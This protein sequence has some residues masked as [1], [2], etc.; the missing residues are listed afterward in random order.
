MGTKQRVIT[1]LAILATG[2]LIML[3]LKYTKSEPKKKADRPKGT[4][5]ETTNVVGGS[6]PVVV[7]ASG[8]VQPAKQIILGSEVS[9]VVTAVNKDFVPG[10]FVKVGTRLVRLSQKDY[11]LVI[12]EQAAQVDQA[13]TQL[14]LEQS[15]K[16]IAEQEWKVMNATGGG[17]SVGGSLALREPQLRTA[18][19]GL[20]AARSGLQRAKRNRAKTIIRAPFNAQ[21]QLKQVDVGQ[22]VTP[23]VPVA[24]LVGTDEYWVQVSL[25]VE[26]LARIQIPGIGGAKEGALVTV[27]Q[28]AGDQIYTWTGHVI[29]L[30]PDLDP[31]GRMARI[32]VRIPDPLGL[33]SQETRQMRLLLGSYVEVEIDAGSIDNVHKVSRRGVRDDRFVYL[34]KKD[35]TL[36]IRELSVVWREKDYVLAREGVRE[37]DRVIVSPMAT[38]VEGMLLR[39][40]GS[41]IAKRPAKQDGADKDKKAS[42]EA[43]K[44]AAKS[45]VKGE[46]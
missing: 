42:A 4:L 44:T 2:I 34:M 16:K 7:R 19:V 13:K 33:Q 1:A 10:G 8:I 22:L 21:V 14:E 5:V 23:G 24:R 37:D 27:R 35:N 26:K 29:R 39:L 40:P 12:Q 20:K 25:A 18:Q 9:G 28:K 11:A 6:F 43:S 17:D 46:Q 38:P 31:V 3:A 30:I 15:R 41:G 45:A 36:Q 32:L